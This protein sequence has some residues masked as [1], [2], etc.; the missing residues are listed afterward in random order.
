MPQ[1]VAV[2]ECNVTR[3]DKVD[4]YDTLRLA[5]SPCYDGMMQKS[6]TDGVM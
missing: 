1:Y 5:A 2:Q 3:H 4:Q 6:A